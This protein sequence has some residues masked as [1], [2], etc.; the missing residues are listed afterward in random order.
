LRRFKKEL[1][2]G[3]GKRYRTKKEFEEELQSLIEVGIYPEDAR[4]LLISPDE[5]DSVRV[6]PDKEEEFKKFRELYEFGERVMIL[7]EHGMELGEHRI[8]DCA[9]IL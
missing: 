4:R 5:V 3:P 7:R 8:R 2:W 6:R 1:P 9:R